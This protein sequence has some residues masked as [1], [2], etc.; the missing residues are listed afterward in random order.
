MYF[1]TCLPSCPCHGPFDLL[2][3]TAKFWYVWL[4]SH[5][6]MHIFSTRADTFSSL[7]L[8]DP[9]KK[10]NQI[11]QCSTLANK[12]IWR[13]LSSR[14]RASKLTIMNVERNSFRCSIWTME[15]KLVRSTPW[16]IKLEF[17]ARFSLQRIYSVTASWSYLCSQTVL[18]NM[19]KVVLGSIAK[20]NILHNY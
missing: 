11:G 5:A 8:G 17:L 20:W 10:T 6:C 16:N 15:T 1:P 12:L 9:F 13:I 7:C 14:N 3:G 4:A 19:S 18:S 2:Q